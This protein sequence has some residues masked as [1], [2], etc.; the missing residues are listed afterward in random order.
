MNKKLTAILLA[1]LMLLPAALTACS[2]GTE[3]ATP[4]ADASNPAQTQTTPGAE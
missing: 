3:N 4:D 1:L 2:Q